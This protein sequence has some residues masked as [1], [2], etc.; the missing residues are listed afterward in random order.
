MVETRYFKIIDQ[1]K[2]LDKD[3]KGFTN[4]MTI[5]CGRENIIKVLNEDQTYSTLPVD[6]HINT[7]ISDEDTIFCGCQNGNVYKLK[8]K[9]LHFLY[10]H[11]N[12]VCSMDLYKE[13]LIT[14]G[15]D[16]NCIVYNTKTG[17]QNHIIHPESVWVSKLY[18]IDHELIQIITGCADGIIR[19]FMYNSNGTFTLIKHYDYHNYPVRDIIKIDQ[20]IYSVD[21]GG[22]IFKIRSDGK[23]LS[24]KD[25]KEMC[26]TSLWYKNNLVVAGDQGK[27]WFLTPHL[28]ELCQIKIPQC[29][30]IWKLHNTDTNILAGGNNGT[31]Y[32]IRECSY[33]E[34]KDSNI[35]S[36]E[37]TNEMNNY[38]VKDQIFTANNQKY[39]ISNNQIFIQTSSG[40]WD[41][42]GDAEKAYDYSFTV[43]VG[44]KNY[45]I[46]FN[47][48][49]DKMMIARKFLETHNLSL[50]YLEEIIEFINANFENTE[51]K[52]FTTLN[53][54]GIQKVLQKQKQGLDVDFIMETLCKIMDN[55][56]DIQVNKLENE[57]KNIEEKYVFYDIYKY[58]VYK[59]IPVDLSFVLNDFI[60]YEKDA[61]A[62]VML[63]TNLMVD[64][65]F[66]LNLLDKRVSALQDQG[67]ISFSDLEYYNNNKILL[68]KKHKYRSS[69]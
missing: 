9:Q 68:N 65:P 64:S 52:L 4:D 41:L 21:N 66:K 54:A 44:G 1:K 40:K 46:N 5:V 12:N 57:L 67:M 32:Q 60:L 16:H 27:V 45:T 10:K 35:L 69:T 28:D 14:G 59:N 24:M 42:I 22:K 15:W 37:C 3:I 20:I 34:W 18:T 29:N 63:I 31:I 36:K 50:N 48:A 11:S 58:L 53:I 2:I 6:S 47:K 39:K 17:I 51:F 7:L 25:T 62:F 38:N 19:I 30:V 49:D 61:R 56:L 55:D 8:D 23:L 13:Y 33:Q 43:E 26:F